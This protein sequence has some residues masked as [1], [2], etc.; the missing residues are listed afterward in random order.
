MEFLSKFSNNKRTH[1]FTINVKI[2][3][4]YRHQKCHNPSG[5]HYLLYLVDLPWILGEVIRT[6]VPN[7]P[8]IQYVCEK[9]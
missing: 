2:K 9:V 5:G 1:N 3:S 8:V 4:G 6:H 7:I